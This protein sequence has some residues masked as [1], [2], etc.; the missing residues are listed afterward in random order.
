MT[1]LTMH[2][3]FINRLKCVKSQ[4]NMDPS[5]LISQLIYDS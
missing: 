4:T 3:S 2:F 5:S 1:I